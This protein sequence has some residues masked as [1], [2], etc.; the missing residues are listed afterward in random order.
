[1]PR[2]S[3]RSLKTVLLA[4]LGRHAQNF[5]AALGRLSRTP[6]SSLMTAAVIGI[7]LALPA[8]LHI[9]VTNGRTLGGQWESALDFSVYLN[10]GVS[11]ESARGIAGGITQR[12]EVERVDVVLAGDALD[13]FKVYSGLGAAVDALDENPLPHALIV[14]PTESSDAQTVATLAAELEVLDDVDL[15]QMDTEW[16]RRFHGMLDVVRRAIDIATV[17]LAVAVL[18]IIGN[19]IRLD[20][21]NRR[22]EI[23]VTKLIGATDA[24]IRRPFLYSGLWYGLSGGLFATL[25]VFTGLALIDEPI[26]RVAGLYGSDFRLTSLDWRETLVLVGSGGLLGWLGSWF[27]AARHMRAIEPG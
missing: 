2:Q 5:V 27:A 3:K 19:T 7:A 25:L 1:M 24:F 17:V 8:A 10:L 11:A 22:D 14:R 15:V 12:D 26:G 23:E 18:I 21:E 9:V 6:M 20:I 13:E 16:V 4:Y